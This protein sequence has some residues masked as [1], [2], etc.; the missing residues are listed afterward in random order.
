VAVYTSLSLTDASRVTEAHGLGEA[1]RLTPIAAGSVNTNY[2]VEGD[3]GKLF[4][5]VYEEQDESGVAYEWALLDHLATR[6]VALPKR[7]PGSEPGQVRIEGKPTALFEVVGGVELCHRLVEPAHMESVGEV[8]ATIHLAGREFEWIKPGRFRR[9][10]I[11]ERLDLAA[12]AAL[13]ELDEPLARLRA[14]LAR[15]ERSPAREVPRG[16]IHGDLFRDNVRFDG[17]RVAAVLDWESASDGVLLYDLAVV[18]L[19]W[20]YGDAFD[21]ALARAFVSAY[22]RVRPLERV[23][24]DALFDVA[25]EAAVRFSATR[26]TD[27]HLRSGEGRVMKDYRRFLARLDALEEMGAEGLLAA[28]R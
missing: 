7:A 4:L 16:V 12:R 3:F 13:P 26:I 6:G 24:W 27:F 22:E 11:V 25:I 21:F 19:A 10:N 14:T 1:T 23:E 2:F 20:C 8:L 18:L 5:R 9:E 17:T 15:L 28:L